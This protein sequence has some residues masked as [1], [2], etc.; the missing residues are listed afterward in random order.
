MFE[1]VQRKAEFTLRN[2]HWETYSGKLKNFSRE[3][4]IKNKN[5]NF[6]EQN[7]DPQVIMEILSTCFDV[8][9]T[10]HKFTDEFVLDKQTISTKNDHLYKLNILCFR[11]RYDLL[12]PYTSLTMRT[13]VF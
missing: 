2:S 1:E 10:L 7:V 6:V 8:K 4:F 12:I 3:D 5:T 11:T 9:I 13:K